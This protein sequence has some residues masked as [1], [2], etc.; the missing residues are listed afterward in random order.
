MA[1]S[2]FWGTQWIQ[3][4]LLAMNCSPC[5]RTMSAT[6]RCGRFIFSVASE[7]VERHPGSRS[8][9]GR[10]DWERYADACATD[11]DRRGGVRG[12]ND[13]VKAGWDGGGFRLRASE[14]RR[15]A[16]GCAEKSVW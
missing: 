9:V 6:S 4:L 11:A 5:A 2:T 16:S 15:S 7:T 8:A 14:W 10:V 12:G 1:R 3:L 13:R